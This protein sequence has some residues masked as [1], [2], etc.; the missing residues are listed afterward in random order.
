MDR[1]V[2]PLDQDISQNLKEVYEKRGIAVHNSAKVLK[3]EKSAKGLKVYFEKAG[4]K[5]AVEAETVLVATGRAPVT[6]VIDQAEI[7]PEMNRRFIAI[8]ENY[9][10]SVDGLYAIGDV[11][12]KSML[13]HSAEEMGLRCADI[14]SGR[15]P[16]PIDYQR[17]PSCLY[18]NPE[19][20]S[21][22]LTQVQ[23]EEAGYKVAVGIFPLM[24]NARTLILNQSANS[25]AKIVCDKETK[26]IL[27][28]HLFGP[29]ATEMI[30]EASLAMELEC[31]AQEIADTI[32]PHPTVSEAIKEAASSLLDGAIH[33]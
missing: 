21:V 4:Q 30:A 24:A 12:G 26:E 6:D 28:V 14:L 33:F 22:G 27:G 18:T 5:Q 31:T 16:R 8:D 1:L 9:R 17:I 11:T 19:A 25:F 15:K 20:A 23:A 10:T 32:H 13:A 2:P 3:I 7:K 29:F